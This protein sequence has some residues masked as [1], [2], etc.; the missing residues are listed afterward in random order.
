MVMYL[1]SRRDALKS[2]CLGVANMLIPG[3]VDYIKIMAGGIQA[4]KQL[5]MDEGMIGF[6]NTLSRSESK[7]GDCI[8]FCPCV[9]IDYYAESARTSPILR[10]IVYNIYEISFRPIQKFSNNLNKNCYHY[11]IEIIPGFILFHFNWSRKYEHYLK[12]GKRYQGYGRLTNCGDPS[13][14]NPF[15]DGTAIKSISR[16]AQLERILLNHIH[17]DYVEKLFACKE[18]ETYTYECAL[19]QLGYPHD[20]IKFQESL[21]TYGYQPKELE[22][23]ALRGPCDALIY[24]VTLT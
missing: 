13:E 4:P 22:S 7:V 17:R 8:S 5:F 23:T 9:K 24:C 14:C 6:N 18:D 15:V 11:L 16:R 19:A 12:V 20:Y 3:K 2:L 1:F 10:H 21:T